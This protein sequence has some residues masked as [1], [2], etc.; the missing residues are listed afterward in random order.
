MASTKLQ[1]QGLAAITSTTILAQILPGITSSSI[2][3]ISSALVVATLTNIV[4]ASAINNIALTGI[5]VSN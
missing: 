2:N 4:N 1:S 3:N 5:Q